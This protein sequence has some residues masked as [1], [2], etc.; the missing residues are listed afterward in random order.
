MEHWMISDTHAGHK[1]ILSLSNRP[2]NTIEEHDDYLVQQ[3]NKVVQ[4][5]D[6]LYHHGD[7]S[8]GIFENAIKFREKI[9]CKNIHLIIGN[10]DKH[11]L[12]KKE[13]IQLFSSV[14]HIV[15]KTIHK[16]RIVMQHYC[17][18]IWDGIQWGAIHT[19]GHSHSKLVVNDARCI[20][21]GVDCEYAEVGHKKYTPLHIS[22]VIEIC[23]NK[24]FK[25][26][27]HH[28]KLTT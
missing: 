27:D 18:R 7:W 10:H 22:Q 21:V 20:D 19:F 26:I 25:P 24:T 5:N 15:E 28:N 4:P 6:I 11:K 17:M 12:H 8:L 23:N 3:I 1:N 16:Q 13:F 2:F 14:N 9:N